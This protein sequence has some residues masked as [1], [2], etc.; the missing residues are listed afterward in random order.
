MVIRCF[1]LPRCGKTTTL[2]MMALQAVQSGKYEHV[3]ANVHLTIPGVT[4]IPFKEVF[5]KYELENCIYF[6]DEATLNAGDRDWKSFG[7]D[8]IAYIMEHGHHKCNLVFFSQDADGI[9]KKIRDV[10]EEV[11]YIYKTKFWGKWFTRVVK[12]PYGIV[13]PNGKN[14]NGETAG[15]I[16]M[17]YIKPPFLN[18]LFARVV[19]RS[20]YY[21]YFDSWEC[22][23]LPP[24]P[25]KYQPYSAP[26]CEA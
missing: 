20:K 5:G 26:V 8:K 16:L 21:H 1:G 22:K 12:V 3:Y 15:R 23:K 13:W 4:W 7:E 2:S 18:R 17:G 19:R 10:T 24:L 25:E 9:D 6:V 11:Y 14:D